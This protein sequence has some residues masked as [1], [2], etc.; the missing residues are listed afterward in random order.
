[1]LRSR[2]FGLAIALGC[3]VAGAPAL[4]QTG[5]LF[6]KATLRDGTPCV[7]CTVRIDRQ[8]MKETFRAETDKKGNYSYGG[9]PAGDY[10]ISLASAEGKTLYQD[11]RVHVGLGPTTQ[12]DLDLRKLITVD[13]LKKLI[14]EDKER[15]M[16]SP[17]RA[18]RWP[19][20][21]SAG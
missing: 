16:S 8:D 21:T 9:L 10:R 3:V 20:A 18:V 4:A 12:A 17:S 11:L 2:D 6:G 5:G 1:M 7:K 15:V 14:A 19:A 13:K